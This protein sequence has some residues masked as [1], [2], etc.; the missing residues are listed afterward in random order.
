MILSINIKDELIK[1]L[2]YGLVGLLNTTIFIIVAYISRKI[3]LNYVLYTLIGYSVA[4]L[5]SFFMNKKYTFN[6]KIKDFKVIFT[7]FLAVTFS[8]LAGVQV[9]QFLLIDVFELNELYGVFLGMVFY[10]GL[11]FILNRF[12]VFKNNS[13][14]EVTC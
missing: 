6:N 2:K 11:G 7:K 3:G 4:I 1:M 14:A 12:F 10:T 13:A 8:L 9:I 5:F